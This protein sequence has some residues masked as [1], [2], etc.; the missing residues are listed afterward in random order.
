[1]TFS[2]R[3]SGKLKKGISSIEAVA[4]SS[5]DAASTGGCCALRP[6]WVDTTTTL[7]LGYET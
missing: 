7:S 5:L 1:M 2:V 4:S 6:L 3:I